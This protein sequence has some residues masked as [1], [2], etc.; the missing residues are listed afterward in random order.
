LMILLVSIEIKQNAFVPSWWTLNPK[1][2]PISWT[3]SVSFLACFQ[4]VSNTSWGVLK[5]RALDGHR[6]VLYTVVFS[7]SPQKFKF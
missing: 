4:V 6:F 1:P 2:M 5:S 3:L 7:A